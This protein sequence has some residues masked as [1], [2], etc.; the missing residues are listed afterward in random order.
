MPASF[1]FSLPT[2]DQGSKYC[3]VFGPFLEYNDN[4]KTILVPPAADVSNSYVYK[5]LGGN[6]YVIVANQNGI[7]SNPNLLGVEYP[8]DQTDRAS[9][10][11]FG[12]NSIISRNGQIMIYSNATSYQNVGSAIN[13]LHVRELLNTIELQV[14]GVLNQ[15]VFDL[16]N[17]ITQLNIINSITPI[18][19]SVQDAGAI[20][21]FTITMDK[22]NN[23]PQIISQGFGIVDIGITVT[24]ALQKIV[25]RITTTNV[26]TNTTGGTSL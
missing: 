25:T 19:Q 16:N 1:L 5:F 4:G 7:L 9:L 2:E 20:S 11:P 6:P 14:I 24:N 12:Y 17:P 10:E 22:T 13:Y 21:S 18:L 15:Y 26:A 23:T 8:F 3:G